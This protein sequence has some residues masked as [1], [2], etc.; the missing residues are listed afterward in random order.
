[1]VVDGEAVEGDAGTLAEATTADEPL[2]WYEGLMASLAD[3][4]G[5]PQE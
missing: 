2:P 1:V 4:D 5:E 3:A